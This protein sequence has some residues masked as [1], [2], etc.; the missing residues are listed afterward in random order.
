MNSLAANFATRALAWRRPATAALIGV[1]VAVALLG[2]YVQVLDAAV[3]R[4]PFVVKATPSPTESC[5][6]Q[7]TGASPACLV[8][9]VYAVH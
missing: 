7:A 2:S 8:P 9:S 4:G 5:N 1:P 3:A 6:A